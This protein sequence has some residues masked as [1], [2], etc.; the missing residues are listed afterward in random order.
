MEHGGWQTWTSYMV[1]T[2]RTMNG[3]E[4]VVELGLRNINLAM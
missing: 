3:L 2:A 4:E 1:S